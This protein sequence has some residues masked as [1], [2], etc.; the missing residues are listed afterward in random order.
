MNPRVRRGTPRTATAKGGWRAGYWMPRGEQ[1]RAGEEATPMER[2]QGRL[3]HLYDISKTLTAFDSV[4]QTV[5]RV[6]ALMSEVAPL[7]S[8][9]LML[10][11]RAGP[12]PRTRSIVWHAEG[13]NPSGVR[14]A[15]AR[16][17][18]A[19]A[20]LSRPAPAFEEE[21]GATRFPTPVPPGPRSRDAG[22]VLL[23]LVVD[24]GRIFGA[25]HL[26]GASRFDEADLAFLNA[27]VNQLAVALDRMAAVTAKEA[28]AT[29]AQV[30]A[31]L[32]A[33]ASAH[34]F[35]SLEYEKTLAAV[36][37][38][39]VPTLADICVLDEL[40]ETGETRRVEVFAADPGN[41][42]VAD[43]L[44]TFFPSQKSQL[45][46][47][48]ALRSGEAVLVEG[49]EA[50]SDD[51]DHA[52]TLKA[53]GAQSM[54]AVPLIAR[55]RTLGVLTFMFAESGRRYLPS[56]LALGKE[57][58][59]RAAIAMD[60]AR[61]YAEAK[62]A[63][64]ARRHLIAVVSHELK[65][66]LGT[67][68]MSTE[69]L[70]GPVPEGPPA[71]LRRIEV[72]ERSAHRMNRLL[73]DLLDM[74][75]LEAGYLSVT[76]KR[77][78][79]GPIVREAVELHALAAHQKGLRL[80]SCLPGEAFEVDCDRDRILQVLGNL[81]GNAIKFSTGG[82]IR[83][84]AR[85]HEGE[86]FFFVADAG[87][88]LTPDEKL[89]VFD[90]YW[91]AQKTASLGTGL[92][93]SISKSSRG[94]SRWPDL[95]RRH[96]GGRGDVLLRSSRGHRRAGAHRRMARS[97]GGIR[98]R[99]SRLTVVG[100]TAERTEWNRAWVVHPRDP[101]GDPLGGRRRRLPRDPRERVGNRGLQRR[102]GH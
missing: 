28:A 93:L 25:L 100:A 84:G 52:S 82:T 81:I 51:P 20:F 86:S 32:L 27:V 64:E 10:E 46:Q 17:K 60:N 78:E 54:M 5:P 72:I 23:P 18:E 43:R 59:L 66:P 2:M 75:T 101:Q 90:Q 88:G 34:L 62:R 38:A 85:P 44:R 87:P 48:R 96:A 98:G 30:A 73:T 58:G 29:A 31:E 95:R 53:S 3:Q 57:I 68:L 74:T 37:H 71:V 14:K 24:H 94:A 36:V 49:F 41:Q 70:K 15:Q 69:L 19:Y 61:L 40:T 89:S 7:G 63:M 56:D 11:E 8:A 13:V 21:A 6:L 97:R 1:S 67:I 92:G 102:P 77:Q 42:S 65:N 22:F 79:G 16:A 33:N 26:E 91:Q 55:G 80:D 4:E 76:K 12:R 45:P 9:V 99:A 35:S 50:W 39:A 47:A 83:V